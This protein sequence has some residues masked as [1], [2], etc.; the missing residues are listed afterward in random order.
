M[1]GTE[2]TLRSSVAKMQSTEG[3]GRLRSST[4][5]M[6]LK[7]TNSKQ[8]KIEERPFITYHGKLHY[9]I[10]NIDCAIMCDKMLAHANK[11]N[12]FVLGFDMEWP[13]NFTTGPDKTAVIQI[14]PSLSECFIY[15]V[16][17]FKNLPVALTELLSH[18]NV[19][20]VGVNIK[21]DIHKLARDFPGV[22]SQ[23]ILA[24][25]IDLRTQANVVLNFQRRW[26]M[27]KLVNHL[28]KLQINKDKRV[29]NSK[30]HV[31]PLSKAQLRYA[32]IDAY[33]SLKLHLHLNDLEKENAPML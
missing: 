12:L 20:L 1:E 11:C 4:A 31:I 2:R 26:S 5:N 30:W 10:E 25:C 27:E 16:Y 33:A 19:R 3:T 29:R 23:P 24:N 21:N 6:E 13:F 7:Q 32:A 14:S 15:H 8:D 22:D 18:P 17:K 28:L 9:C